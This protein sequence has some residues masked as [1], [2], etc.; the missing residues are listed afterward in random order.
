[1]EE[2]GGIVDYLVDK[3]LLLVEEGYLVVRVQQVSN[4][5][6]LLAEEGYP[7]VRVQRESDASHSVENE[8]ISVHLG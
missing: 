2:W 1:M 5:S 4:A 3:A 7:V 6:L 8:G